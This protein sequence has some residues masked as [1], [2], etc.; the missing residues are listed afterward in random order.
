MEDIYPI[1]DC[2]DQPG[3][4]VVAVVTNVMGS[5]YKKEG[6]A[7]AFF[8]DGT[9]IGMISAGCLEED[10]AFRA[11]EV[12]KNEKS[13][14][15]QFDLRDETD[16]SWGQGPGCNGMIEISLVYMDERLQEN[17]KKLKN[18]LYSNIPVL[19]W[20]KQDEYLFVPKRGK[21]FGV[22]QESTTVKFDF[23]KTGMIPGMPVYQHCFRPKPRLIIFGAGPDTRPLSR[24]AI[25]TGFSVL[26]C[27][28]REE[29][30]NKLNFP[31]KVQLQVGFPN[32]LIK[33]IPF[34]PYDFIVIA[35]HHFQRDKE[36]LSYLKN[37]NVFYI[38]VLG[39]KERTKRLLAGNSIQ[40]KIH[41]PIGLS[42][43]AIGP[44]EIA[45]SIMAELIKEWQ[46]QS[47]D[48]SHLWSVSR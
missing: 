45:I 22:W 13:A 6:S 47:T 4:K 34:S 3:K 10:L 32:E 16:L 36:L 38:G 11:Q 14:S 25:M 12:M 31:E 15:T 39:S 9:R 26:I 46:G 44:E 24:I 43:G 33:K 1:L 28:W 41:S 30:C 17:L 27:D 40:H 35:T 18:F 21:P 48:K 8:E 5:A 42:I 37:E 7:M 29:Y 19:F 23:A 20:K 2:L